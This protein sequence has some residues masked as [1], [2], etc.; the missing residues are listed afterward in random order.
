MLGFGASY[1]RDLT[2]RLFIGATYFNWLYVSFTL[3]NGK[4]AVGV[5]L[6]S[7]SRSNYCNVELVDIIVLRQ[8]QR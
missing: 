2:V 8:K 4:Y 1:I 5:V 7:S 3:V 6:F